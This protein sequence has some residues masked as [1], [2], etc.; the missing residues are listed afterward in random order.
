MAISPKSASEIRLTALIRHKQL[1]TRLMIA[2]FGAAILSFEVSVAAAL[3]WLGLNLVSQFFD[4]W[5]WQPV[6][7]NG[8]QA[9]SRRDVALVMFSAAQA[10]ACYSLIAALLWVYGEAGGFVFS[11][12]W[13]AGAL[14][15]VTLHMHHN[16]AVFFAGALP[17]VGYMLL[18]PLGVAVSERSG[19]AINPVVI[20]TGITLYIGHLVAAFL[21]TR[22]MSK[23]LVSARYEAE[24]RQ[25]EAE[26]ASRAKSDFLANMSH[27]IRTPLNGILGLAE[28]L[29]QENLSE[30]VRNKIEL[31]HGS[32]ELLLHLLNDILD[33]SKIENRKMEL[34]EGP[35]DLAAVCARIVDI[36]RHS[37]EDAGLEIVMEVEPDAHLQR[38][39][40]KLRL[41]QIVNNLISNA[42]KFTDE[43]RVHLTLGQDENDRVVLL[44]RDTGIGMSEE[45]LE[46]V[47]K[48]FTQ[49]DAS[50]AGRYGGTGL[51]LA[52]VRGL[53]SQ[54]GGEMTAESR[55]GVG[56]LFTVRLPLKRAQAGRNAGTAPVE[57]M[58]RDVSSRDGS[59]IRVLA[60]D[61]N[62]VNR[63]VIQSLLE[64]QGVE[65]VLAA[66]GLEAVEYLRHEPVDMVLMDI[67]MPVMDGVEAMRAIRKERRER[68]E[69]ELPIIAVSAHAMAHEVENFLREGFTDYAAKPV[70][71]E[72]LSRLLAESFPNTSQSAA[73]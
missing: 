64:A 40:D 5:A 41:I 69:P 42:I 29:R 56:S 66:D 68:G 10:S 31:M 26:R 33:L 59:G 7:K 6:L 62:M 48:P 72:A 47:G 39:G 65:V 25:A 19:V 22:K 11:Y 63:M 32:G 24:A 9:M 1:K 16:R 67:A 34:A 13:L 49:A 12:L 53:V 50:I 18:L 2:G 15:H 73:A 55:P 8:R 71:G 51:G 21:A 36:H 43:G 54:M 14:L 28:A 38:L 4:Y 58:V 44:V 30:S 37:A 3:L 35:V 17:H 20:L 23:Q 46:T 52:I 27:E 61:D 57:E 45:Q 70:S 60:V